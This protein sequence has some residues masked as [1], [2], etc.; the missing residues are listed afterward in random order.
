MNSTSGEGGDGTQTRNFPDTGLSVIVAGS[1][2]IL[3]VLSE[4]GQRR[5][6]AEAIRE[7]GFVIGEIISGTARGVD[8]LG[9][10]WAAEHD[11]PVERFPADW[12]QHGKSAGYIRNEEMAEYADALVAVHVNESLGAGHMIDIGHDVLGTDRVHRVPVTTS[13]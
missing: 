1:R 2:S 12:N 4:S 13:T 7:S 9:E 5:I 10:E 6:V 11:I 8:Q 3:A